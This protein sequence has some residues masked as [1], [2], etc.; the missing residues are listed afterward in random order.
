MQAITVSCAMP[1]QYSVICLCKADPY[2]TFF[3]K[4]FLAVLLVKEPSLHRNGRGGLGWTYRYRG[5]Y[6]SAIADSAQITHWHQCTDCTL[7]AC[8]F[9]MAF[10]VQDV[11]Y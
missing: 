6:I 3:K 2:E 9:S 4:W 1:A 7:L 10:A 5:Q 8:T 11:A